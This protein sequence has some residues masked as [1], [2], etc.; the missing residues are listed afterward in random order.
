MYHLSRMNTITN[1]SSVTLLLFLSILCYYISDCA[2]LWNIKVV[3]RL[4]LSNYMSSLEYQANSDNFSKI[5]LSVVMKPKQ[6][7][8]CHNVQ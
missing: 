1:H 4:E 3:I 5:H 8:K 2:R 7:R 6:P